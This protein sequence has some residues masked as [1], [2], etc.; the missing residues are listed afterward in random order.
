[1]DF[2]RSQGPSHVQIYRLNRYLISSL[3]ALA[4]LPYGVSCRKA[5]YKAFSTGVIS[6]S[7]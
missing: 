7:N 5:I 4:A 2:R 3:D 6:V 1:M